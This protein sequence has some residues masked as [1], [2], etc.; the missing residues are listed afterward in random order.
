MA[1]N[2][3]NA[4]LRKLYLMEVEY[5]RRGNGIWHCLKLIDSGNV[6]AIRQSGQLDLVRR[7]ASKWKPLEVA[8]ERSKKMG[9]LVPTDGGIGN[10][11]ASQ[12]A[13]QVLRPLLGA[14]AEFLP[15]KIVGEHELF[16]DPE[17]GKLSEPYPTMSALH[18]LTYVDLAPNAEATYIEG[19][20]ATFI[21]EVVRYA[22]DP[23][24]IHDKHLFKVRGDPANYLAS[25]ALFELVKRA[26]LK[27]VVFKPVP[28]EVECESSSSRRARRRRSPESQLIRQVR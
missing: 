12:K 23:E 20:Y 26:G 22:F 5:D 27:G 6:K 19:P 1:I 9:D 14:G 10:F 2:T 16:G 15:L 8:V 7:V 28:Y 18:C 4:G 13:V 17:R 3:R 25:E 24:D 21:A 11:A